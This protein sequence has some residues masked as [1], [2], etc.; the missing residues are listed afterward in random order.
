MLR[1][2]AED[3]EVFDFWAFDL[4]EPVSLATHGFYVDAIYF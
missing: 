3:I 2:L 1:E 4:D